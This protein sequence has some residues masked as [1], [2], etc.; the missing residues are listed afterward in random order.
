MKEIDEFDT[1]KKEYAMKRFTTILCA[2]VILIV[3][4]HTINAR[5][6]G[7]GLKGGLNFSNFGGDDAGTWDSR[8]G[9]SF[10]GFLVSSFSDLFSIQPELLYTTKGAKRTSTFGVG[11]RETSTLR[12]SYLEIP[13][14]G[15]ITIPLRNSNFQPLLYAG[16]YMAIKLSSKMLIESDN[17][18]TE[19]SYDDARAT[20]FGLVFGGGV[21]FPVRENIIGLEVRYNLGLTSFDDSDDNF[22]IKHT[23]V[24]VMVSFQI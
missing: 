11:D 6:P 12:F 15:K 10:G 22:S 20:D 8:T 21:G 14:L 3:S 17:Q 4:V 24:M 5:P 18:D 23:V 7:F 13:I 1:F 2:L 9:F 19:S 16:P